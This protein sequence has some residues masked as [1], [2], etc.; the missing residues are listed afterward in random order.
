VILSKQELLPDYPGNCDPFPLPTS[1]IGPTIVR[2]IVDFNDEYRLTV[3]RYP[4]DDEFSWVIFTV[5]P[6]GQSE[7]FVCLPI[8]VAQDQ[9]IAEDY[10]L[11]QDPVVEDVAFCADVTGKRS[12]AVSN[13]SFAEVFIDLQK[14]FQIAWDLF[15]GD[16]QISM[17]AYAPK[18]Y[19]IGGAPRLNNQ[20]ALNGLFYDPNESGHGIDLNVFSVGAIVYY[21]GHRSN[22]ERLWLIS[23]VY[24]GQIQFGDPLQVDMFEVIEGKFFDPI[25]NSS[26]WGSMS[27][28]F[29]D[30]DNGTA[31]LIGADG[32]NSMRFVRLAGLDGEDC[33]DLSTVND[34]QAD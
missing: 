9:T 34:S 25:S 10:T 1:P 22:G 12:F 31:E 17:F 33:L 29:D 19:G 28:T 5:D 13:W 3:W 24:G 2:D 6:K 7:P 30:C 8:I 18:E 15:G 32:S 20:I 26:F 21:Y 27:L 14:E 16:E 4:C 11:T 23:E